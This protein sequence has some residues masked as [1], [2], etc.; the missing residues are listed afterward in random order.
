MPKIIVAD[1]C[2]ALDAGSKSPPK[3]RG[4]RVRILLTAVLDG[5]Y[6]AGFTDELWREWR[7]HA[8]LFAR[9]WLVTMQ[10]RRKVKKLSPAPN[11]GLKARALATAPTESIHDEMEK[12]WHLCEAALDTDRTVASSDDT[13]R[14]YFATASASV[15]ALK[16]IVWVNPA[17]EDLGDWMDRGAPD[18]VDRRLGR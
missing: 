13:A 2:L 16:P 11:F 9:R 8:A 5:D 12:D 6:S 4:A 18:E 1:A 17:T 3:E 10:S 7:K 15:A 14:S